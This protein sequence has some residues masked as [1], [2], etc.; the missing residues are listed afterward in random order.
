M[1]TSIDGRRGAARSKARTSV[2]DGL[3]AVRPGDLNFAHVRRFVDRIDTVDDAEIID[4]VRWLFV[5]R[6]DRCRAERRRH[7][8]RGA[9][10]VSALHRTRRRDRQRR[11]PGSGDL[12]NTFPNVFAGDQEVGDRSLLNSGRLTS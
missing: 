3:M 5:R 2:A 8:G 7:G 6:Q 4:A 10:I 1:K 9:A 11:Q 12:R